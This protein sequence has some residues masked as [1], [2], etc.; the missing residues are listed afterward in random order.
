M[1]HEALSEP[2]E[3]L[4][5]GR[6]VRDVCSKYPGDLVLEHLGQLPTIDTMN[7]LRSAIVL[8]LACLALVGEAQPPLDSLRA[9]LS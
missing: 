5:K 6:R 8:I 9:V 3:G 2:V 1:D 7:Q 4:S